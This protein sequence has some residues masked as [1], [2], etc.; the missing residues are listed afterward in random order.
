MKTLYVTQHAKIADDIQINC[1]EKDKPQLTTDEC[2]IKIISSGINPSDALA[3]TGYF[4]HAALPRIPGRDFAGLVIE[5][6]AQ[7]KGKVVWGTGGAAGISSDGTQAEFITLSSQE[8]AECPK[9]LD[10]IIAGAQPLPYVTAYY[11]LVKRAHIEPHETVLVIGALGQVGSAAM[12]ICHWKK[13]NAIALV[14]GKESLE[15]AKALGWNAIDGDEKNLAEKIKS[16]NHGNPVNVILNSVGNIYWDDLMTSLAEFGRIVTIGARENLREVTI[17]LFELYR[18][19][20]DLIGINSVS[21]D[22]KDNA[23]LLN[24]LK[25]GF[26]ANQLTPLA[27]DENMIF[28]P[29]NASEAYKIVLRGSPK[30]AVIKFN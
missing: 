29:E 15:K 25:A 28:S 2:L 24:E 1:I 6:P 11:G 9:T 18:A 21:L 22:F 23:V 8:I 13:C 17:N 14:R 12:S 7:W 20:Q 3:A 5:G 4:H 30:R 26:E 10:P 16:A 19:N 27:V